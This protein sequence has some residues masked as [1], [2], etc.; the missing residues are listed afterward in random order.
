MRCPEFYC[1]ERVMLQLSRRRRNACKRFETPRKTRWVG[2][3]GLSWVRSSRWW[4]LSSARAWS[5]YSVEHPFR[6]ATWMLESPVLSRHCEASQS[7]LL[8]RALEAKPF[9]LPHKALE[10]NRFNPL[11]RPQEDSRS[12]HLRKAAQFNLINS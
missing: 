2:I 4:W 3:T 8:R 5:K 11:C 7:S 1:Q 6:E 12:S 10:V 9:S